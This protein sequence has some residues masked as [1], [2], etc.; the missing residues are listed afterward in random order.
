MTQKG[1]EGGMPGPDLAPAA[2]GEEGGGAGGQQRV[3]VCEVKV[4]AGSRSWC[5]KAGK[6][7]R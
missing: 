2:E 5:T 7:A 3:L 1:R 6:G 4:G